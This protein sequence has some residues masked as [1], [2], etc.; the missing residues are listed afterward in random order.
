M[1]QKE[2]DAEGHGKGTHMVRGYS[3]GA[4]RQ[5]RFINRMITS[6]DSC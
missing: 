2:A 4:A 5:Q 3:E 6:S 1:G